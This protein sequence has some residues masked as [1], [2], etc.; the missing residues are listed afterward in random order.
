VSG[1]ILL[2]HSQLK[3]AAVDPKGQAAGFQAAA[4]L[5]RDLMNS[6]SA[7]T[8]RVRDLTRNLTQESDTP[9]FVERFFSEHITEFYIRD[10][11]QMR[12]ENHPLRRRYDI[13]D[14]VEQLALQEPA[15]SQLLQGYRELPG[16]E[17][18]PVEVT[19]ARDVAHFNRLLD[20]ERFLARMDRVI[21][22]ATERALAYLGYR[23]KATERLD[24]ILENIAQIAPVL[25][26]AKGVIRGPLRTPGLLLHDNRLRFPNR[27]TARPPR[28]AMTR[29]E[30]T[31]REK[32]DI[33]VR[34]QMIRNRDITPK[35]LQRYV[36]QHVAP[37]E[38]V[39]AVDLPVAGV[40]DAVAFLGLL[41]LGRKGLGDPREFRSNP[42]LRGLDF[43]VVLETGTRLN[44]ALYETT[45]FTVR[46]RPNAA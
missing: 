37:G 24:S 10:F 6:L 41:R 16:A 42:L 14:L 11:R 17:K 18:E 45:D 30:L 12:T 38:S 8:L 25:W 23:L 35:A 44:S 7:T 13:V 39:R 9:S 46:R 36:A 1:D 20:V 5:C 4:R 40:A 32:A 2:I 22:T 33:F 27:P 34:K 21:N 19:L 28:L 29:R 26:S 43:E 3:G 31:S 15:R